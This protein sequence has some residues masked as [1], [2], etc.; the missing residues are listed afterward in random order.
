MNMEKE[1]I[2]LVRHG[3]HLAK[4]MTNNQGLSV[5][6]KKQVEDLARKIKKLLKEGQIT[7]I[8]ST[9]QRALETTEIIREELGLSENSVEKNS[10]L[11]TK[12]TSE[13]DFDWLEDLIKKSSGDI[14]II[15]THIYYVRRYP[16]HKRKGE[17]SKVDFGEAILDEKG[18]ISEIG[19]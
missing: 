2:F 16:L 10:K 3:C 19:R 15:V 9:A 1:Q 11:W 17:R 5:E 8:T 12:S 4:E 14:I 6:G 18:H 13:C 7:I